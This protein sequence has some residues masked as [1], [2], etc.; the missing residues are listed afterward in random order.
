MKNLHRRGFDLGPIPIEQYGASDLIENWS[1]GKPVHLP[2][3][4]SSLLLTQSAN[5]T[6]SELFVLDILDEKDVDDIIDRPPYS[7]R[8][9][10][11]FIMMGSA[12][13]QGDDQEIE[14]VMFDGVDGNGNQLEDL[15]MK[16]SWLS[17]HDED[18][19]L[20]FR[21]S[22]GVDLAE[23]VA[24]D[25]PRQQAAAE[26]ASALFPESNVITE[27]QALLEKISLAI[28]EKE[29]R[30]VERIIYFNAPGGGAYLHHDL[31]R[32]HA[33]V[34]YAQLTGATVWLALPFYQLVECV[35]SFM[36]EHEPPKSLSSE[37][38]SELQSLKRPAIED[39]LNSFANDSL[40]HLINETPEFVQYLIDA[41]H[42]RILQAGDALLLP[43][44]DRDNCCW[45]SVFCL[46]DEMGE[47]LSFAIR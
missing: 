34:V 45:H 44:K 2:N 21:F 26:L 46:G 38:A 5:L 7:D 13:N 14:T 20:R 6:Q 27:N 32:G 36:L 42:Y 15:W 25:A 35:T 12:F 18:A 9:T 41:G 11:N 37:Q 19:S 22:F 8:I 43:Q 10:P 29:L 39:E 30:F 23:D 31:E 40:I 16:V 33:G 24:A 47:A 17:F 3:A 28:S 4:C 1:L